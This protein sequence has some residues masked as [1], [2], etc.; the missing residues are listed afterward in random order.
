MAEFNESCRRV[1]DEQ[2]A[3]LE[4]HVPPAATAWFES[5]DRTRPSCPI[6]QGTLTEGI[7]EAVPCTAGLM[8]GF[9]V[10]LALLGWVSAGVLGTPVWLQ[11]NPKRRFVRRDRSAT[12]SLADETPT[13]ECFGCT[14]CGF[15]TRLI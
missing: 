1:F 4:E 15:V 12:I 10:W 9:F 13:G 14:A 11:Q 6:C 3:R 7:I 8:R 5:P 2:I